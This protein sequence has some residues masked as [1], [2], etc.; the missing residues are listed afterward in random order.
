MYLK[1]IELSG[2]KSFAKSSEL[3]F[4]SSVSAIVGPNGSG[5]S[6]VAEAFRFVLGEQSIKSLR[7][8]KGEDLIFNGGGNE[9][10]ANRASVKVTFDNSNQVFGIDFPE[11]T[12]ERVVH[13]DGVN[14]YLINGS[15]V[16]L[17]DVIEL[18]LRAHIGASGHH[19]ISQGEADKI[20]NS[21]SK[22]R[23]S[24]IEDALGLRIYQYKRVESDRKL[25]K[26]FENIAQVESLRKEIAPHLRFLRKQVE[27]VEKAVGMKDE[28]LNLSRDYFKRE[29]LYVGFTKTALE[30]ERTPIESSLKDLSRELAVAKATLEK[31]AKEDKK[32]YLILDLE[33]EITGARAHKDGL[34]REFG[35]VE[36][37]LAAEERVIRKQRELHTS[38]EHKMIRLKEVEEFAE[39]LK[40][41]KPE[42]NESPVSVIKNIVSK[43]LLFIKGHKESADSSLIVEAEEHIKELQKEK[44]KLETE[45]Q[46]AEKREA[47]LRIQYEE[48]KQKIEEGKDSGRDAEK[49][50]FRIMSEENDLISK[51]NIIKV[52][53]ESLKKDA[54]ELMREVEEVGFLVGREALQFK[55]IDVGDEVSVVAEDRK[56]QEERKREIEKLKIRLED[57]GLSGS[58][59]VLKEY[60]DVTER[61][62]FLTRELLD[63]EKSAE[64]LHSLIKDLEE[65]LAVEFSSGIDKINSEFNGLFNTMFGGGDA[66]LVLTKEKKKKKDVL[67]ED[68]DADIGDDLDG[69]AEVVEEGL[70]ISVNL[71]RKKIRGLLM[72]SGGERALTSIAL[73]F[74]I[75]QVNPPPFIILDETDA[76]L[77]E[78]NSKRYG[79]MVEKL[80]AHSQLILITHN[81]ETMSR[82]GVIY[83]VT[84][85][86]SGISKLLSISFDEA[87]EVAK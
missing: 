15:S 84:M 7:G 79:D 41:I 50:V 57:S 6:N 13:R 47:D 42:D 67:I 32:D 36:G 59:E 20:L 64:S 25:K 31:L 1:S 70:D 81:R 65:R 24:M 16:R 19:I 17:K 34:T 77:D 11:V 75:S 83:G 33:A 58:E 12:I 5:K 80:S 48:L 52:R 87:A 69:D 61:D 72:L 35:R 44:A 27:K 49:A 22:E 9:S 2:F 51:L 78:A 46:K 71:P 63:L 45:I 53:E 28:L 38:D 68:A 4:N 62:E 26:T 74:A 14:D 85:G 37:S 86:S 8:K 23:K 18:L 39:S 3:V 40:E 21:S 55:S 82:A 10:R 76:A 30:S 43:L 54:D 66:H 60:K 73:L 29:D 56:I